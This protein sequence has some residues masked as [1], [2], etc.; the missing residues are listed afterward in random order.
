LQKRRRLGKDEE[1]FEDDVDESEPEV[2]EG[3]APSTEEE[4]IT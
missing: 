4:V 3:E 2:E 1:H